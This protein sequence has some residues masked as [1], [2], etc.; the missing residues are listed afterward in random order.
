[1][2]T[3]FRSAVGSL[4]PALSARTLVRLQKQSNA[5]EDKA[6]FWHSLTA[7]AVVGGLTTAPVGGFLMMAMPLAMGA[8]PILPVALLGAAAVMAT[9]S[10]I[11]SLRASALIRKADRLND[12]IE[13]IRESGALNGSMPP[14]KINPH[15]LASRLFSRREQTLLP[16][17][18]AAQAARIER[19]IAL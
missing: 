3:A 16:A 17:P 18:V 15:G 6:S 19:K 4:S 7:K 9:T 10:L 1:M 12:K 5:A 2:T 11:G 14:V 13:Y 8:F